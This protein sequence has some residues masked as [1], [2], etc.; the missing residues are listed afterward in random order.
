M[1]QDTPNAYSNDEDSYTALFSIRHRRVQR[2]SFAERACEHA[3]VHKGK[4]PQRAEDHGFERLSGG[5]GFRGLG[6]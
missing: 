4:E 5:L 6:V 2:V 1:V 3:G